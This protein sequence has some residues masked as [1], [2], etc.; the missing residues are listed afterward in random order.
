[1]ISVWGAFFPMLERLL[2]HW[3]MY[4]A[5]A[6]RQILGTLV[7]FPCLF[8]ERR[9]IPIPSPRALGHLALMGAIGVALGSFLTSVGVAFSSGFS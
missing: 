7:L 3:D 5:T 8:F 1:M 2:T 4:T 9:R 6:G